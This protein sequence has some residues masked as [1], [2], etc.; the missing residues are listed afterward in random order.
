MAHAREVPTMALMGC[1][2][3]RRLGCNGDA[4]PRLLIH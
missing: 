1:A 2:I 4:R 3:L